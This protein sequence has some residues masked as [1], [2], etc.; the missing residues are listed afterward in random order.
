M[1]HLPWLPFSI[2][3]ARQSDGSENGDE[4]QHRRDFKGQ[5]QL[6]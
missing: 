3:L 1:I 5:Q 2:A 6:V 4:N